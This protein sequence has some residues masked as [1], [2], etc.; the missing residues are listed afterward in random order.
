MQAEADNN[1]NNDAS[2]VQAPDA[3]SP[4]LGA[5]QVLAATASSQQ[6]NGIAPEPSRQ[7]RRQVSRP[8]SVDGDGKKKKMHGDGKSSSKGRSES[9]VKS[10]SENSSE[11]ENEQGSGNSGS[12]E[13]TDSS[14]SGAGKSSNNT[15][16]TELRKGKWTVSS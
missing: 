4:L 14:T 3:S 13:N 7:G 15:K 12:E 1:C 10:S 9:K 11:S 16:S 5:L 8:A 2:S 6:L